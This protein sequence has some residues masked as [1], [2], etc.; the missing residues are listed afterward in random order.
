MA[1]KPKRPRRSRKQV[2]K[3]STGWLIERVG[4]EPDPFNISP[5]IIPKGKSYQWCLWDGDWQ[6]KWLDG[7]WK[8]VPSRRHYGAPSDKHGRIYFQGQMLMERKLDAIWKASADGHQAAITMAEQ[9]NNQVGLTR[10]K[11]NWNAD[12]SKFYKPSDAY[13]GRIDRPLEPTIVE[14]SIKICLT[15]REVEAAMCSNLSNERY[16]ENKLALLLAQRFDPSA[17]AAL[18]PGE[19]GV[20]AFAGLSFRIAAK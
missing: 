20:F 4:P 15:T 12:A 6:H 2:M 8:H 9:F 10:T 16:A 13:D 3:V 7:G 5:S 14:A 18:V 19:K 1:T 11:P 17:C